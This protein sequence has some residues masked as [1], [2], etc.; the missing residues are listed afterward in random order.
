MKFRKL[1][2]C[3][4][5]GLVILAYPSTHTY[6]AEDTSVTNDGSVTGTDES[7]DLAED[8][9]PV[10]STEDATIDE[11]ADDGGNTADDA[12]VEETVEVDE[13]DSQDASDTQDA[14]DTKTTDKKTVKKIT[15]KK[16]EL[17]LLSALI[18]C[19]AG[20]ESYQGKLA[21]GIVVMNRK[22]SGAFPDTVKGVIYQRHQFGPA[23]NGALARALSEYDRGN[24]TS[25]DEKECIKAAK[26]AL[27]GTRT[28]TVNGKTKD[29]SK[30]LFFSTYLNNYT[31]ELGHHK[32][33]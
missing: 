33:K 5:A 9:M 25:G 3:L 15:Y 14:K 10:Q 24:F 6:A 11:T 26:A 21:V 30:Y 2:I 20:S 17:R 23:S 27:S 13:E 18:Y 29:F 4:L 19:E 32:F 12:E 22:K 16:S 1:F 8:G 31:F 7:T 28:I